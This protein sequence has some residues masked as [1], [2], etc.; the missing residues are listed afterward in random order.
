MQKNFDAVIGQLGGRKVADGRLPTEVVKAW[1]AEITE[2]FKSGVDPAAYRYPEANSTVWVIRRD[3]GDIW[4]YLTAND[5]RGGYVVGRETALTQTSTLMGAASL[6]Q[7]IDTAGKVAVQVNFAT[8]RT[9][10][11]PDSQPQIDEI[12]RLLKVNPALSLS[13]NGHTDDTGSAAHNQTLSEAR[14]RSVVAALVAQGIPR[15][16]LAPAGFGNTQPVAD[17][18][19]EAG[20]AKNRRVELVK[21]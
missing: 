17:N 15:A 20:K 14:A 11:L 18:S 12:V 1:G 6:K 19:S 3:D 21:R 2:G 4:V 7:A 13:I 5:T 16:T 9:E 10:I 8:D